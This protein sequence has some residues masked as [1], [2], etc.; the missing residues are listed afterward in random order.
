MKM[1]PVAYRRMKNVLDARDRA[2]NPEF[3]ALWNKIF[4]KLFMDAI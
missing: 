4:D 3:K 2:R 1:N